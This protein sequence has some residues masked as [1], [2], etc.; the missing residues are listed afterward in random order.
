ML[1]ETVYKWITKRSLKPHFADDTFK[2]NFINEKCFHFDSNC[3]EFVP[4]G[5]GDKPW[6]ERMSK[7]WPDYPAYLSRSRYVGELLLL[8]IFLDEI[9]RI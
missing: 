2:R 7:Y 9:E 8:I 4:K 6:S 1:A 3:T 5:P